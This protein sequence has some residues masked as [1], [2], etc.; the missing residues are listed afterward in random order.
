MGNYLSDFTGKTIDKILKGEI[1]TDITKNTTIL[2]N[3]LIIA[4]TGIFSFLNEK[5]LEGSDFEEIFNN[6]AI[7]TFNLNKDSPNINFIS[8][9]YTF[10]QLT[11]EFYKLTHL[12]ITNTDNFEFDFY[13]TQEYLILP[14]NKV[15]LNDLTIELTC[16]YLNQIH[17]IYISKNENNYFEIQYWSVTKQ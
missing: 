12:K 14:I 13:F 8:N 17:R 16:T 15:F 11:N 7:N 6:G 9:Y 3:Q 10:N 5:I 1:I 4:S 2:N